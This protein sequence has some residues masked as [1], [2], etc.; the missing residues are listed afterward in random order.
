MT[1]GFLERLK[2]GL[3]TYINDVTT[4]IK[5]KYISEES[6]QSAKRAKHTD[7]DEGSVVD[8]DDDDVDESDDNED[9]VDEPEV[10]VPVEDDEGRQESR[11]TEEEDTAAEES[12][13]EVGGGD[14][15]SDTTVTSC[16]SDNETVS[17]KPS[18]TWR[19][20][21]KCRYLPCRCRDFDRCEQ[22]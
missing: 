20:Q 18:E 19:Y 10:V 6:E 5:R 21:I 1:L 9:D 13:A 8:W 3:G 14:T 22:P 2:R 11:G 17:E 4:G 16:S 7:F 12:K 15:V